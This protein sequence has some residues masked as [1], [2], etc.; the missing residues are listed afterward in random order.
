MR[1]LQAGLR[2]HWPAFVYEGGCA[3]ELL[4]V[5]LAARRHGYFG[6]HPPATRNSATHFWSATRGGFV[7]A[8]AAKVGP[9]WGAGAVAH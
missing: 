4:L 6:R 2:R 1:Q 3:F 8:S 9:S 5:E 7:L